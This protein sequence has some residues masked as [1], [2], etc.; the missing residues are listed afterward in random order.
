MVKNNNKKTDSLVQIIAKNHKRSRY[1]FLGIGLTLFVMNI[2]TYISF[3]RD[4]SYS[5]ALFNTA[6]FSAMILILITVYYIYE[7]EI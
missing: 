7:D 3:V 1:I 2:T 6:I 5:F 4:M